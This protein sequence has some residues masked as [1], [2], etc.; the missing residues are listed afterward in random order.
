MRNGK[1]EHCIVIGAYGEECIMIGLV[2]GLA[3]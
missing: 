1:D 3:G 2:M